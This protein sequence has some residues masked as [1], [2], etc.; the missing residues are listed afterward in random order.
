MGLDH[1]LDRN[2]TDRGAAEVAPRD[3]EEHVDVALGPVE[4]R[5]GEGLIVAGVA[6]D[7]QLKVHLPRS[8]GRRSGGACV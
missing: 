3:V 4:T 5:R 8:N 2:A 1:E 7:A 6:G